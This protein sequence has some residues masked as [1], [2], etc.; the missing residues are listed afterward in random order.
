[1]V[2]GHEFAG[3]VVAFGSNVSDFR[4]GDSTA[5]ATATSAGCPPGLLPEKTKHLQT[6]RFWIS[7]QSTSGQVGRSS[8]LRGFAATSSVV[9]GFAADARAGS[10]RDPQKAGGRAARKDDDLQVFLRERRGSNPRPPA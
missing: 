1:M 4:V 8:V 7:A 9:R 10:V 2:V 3:E 5:V 6:A